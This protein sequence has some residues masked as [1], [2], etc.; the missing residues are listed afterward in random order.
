MR[1]RYQ[2][3]LVPVDFGPRS[4]WAVDVA[5]EVAQV[6]SSRVTLLHVVESIDSAGEDAE[7]QDFLQRCAQRAEVDLERYAQPFADI[8]LTVDFHVVTGRRVPEV[9]GW[10]V[11][12][13]VDLIV[14]SSHPVDPQHPAQSLA[15][16]SYQVALGAP[17]SVFLVKTPASEQET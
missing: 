17:C 16:L 15:T 1:S 14:L 10:T 4:Q 11:A 13:S 6:N 3:I 2:H 5:I 9:I 12:H 8:G 7:I